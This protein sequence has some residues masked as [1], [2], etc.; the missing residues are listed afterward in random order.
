MAPAFIRPF[1][2]ADLPAAARLLAQR[3][4]RHRRTSPLLSPRYE[5]EATTLAEVSNAWE[6]EG[7]SGCVAL[8]GDEVVGYLLGAPK[9]STVWG[10]NIWVEAAGMATRDPETMRDLYGT[11]A[12][13]WYDEGKTAHYALIPSDDVALIDAWFRLGFGAQHAHAVMTPP[14]E[15]PVVPGGLAVRR[16]GRRDLDALAELDLALPAHQGLS[17]V[18]SAGPVGTLEEARQEWEEDIDSDYYA[19]FV[20]E[21]NGQVIGA[22]VGCPLEK[23]STHQGL[24]RP[25]HSAILGFAAVFPDARGSGAGQALGRAVGR[26]AADEG[27]E[28]LVT[29]W[30]VTNLLSSRTWPKLGYRQT[31][32]RVHRHLGY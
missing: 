3:H 32:L 4:R 15:P 9:T 31:F 26:W 22:A 10:P 28:T 21:R 1:A 19:S 25:E 23:S 13:R 20:A 5:D 24:S 30:R 11:A 18:F 12:T 8:D 7:A 29:D 14:T 16:A 2:A 6:T 27:F 17:P